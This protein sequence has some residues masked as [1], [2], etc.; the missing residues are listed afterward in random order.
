MPSHHACFNRQ[1]SF[2]ADD[3]DQAFLVYTCVREVLPSP[4]Q[5][6]D[7]LAFYTLEVSNI[8]GCLL[9]TCK[10]TEFSSNPTEA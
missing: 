10:Y 7:Q 9:V 4:V 3:K 2:I 6:L 8:E 5:F 1:S